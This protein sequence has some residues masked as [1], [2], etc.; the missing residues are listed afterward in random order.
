MKHFSKKVKK[1]AKK[2][3]FEGRTVKLHAAHSQ[4][5]DL[6][7]VPKMLAI[8]GKWV[9]FPILSLRGRSA[10]IANVPTKL[11]SLS[12]EAREFSLLSQKDPVCQSHYF[13]K[14]ISK[15]KKQKK[16]NTYI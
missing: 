9:G 4:I 5:S 12:F 14:Y 15:S 3:R 8:P 16:T 13:R 7:Y 10:R 6:H 11:L 1:K 2:T